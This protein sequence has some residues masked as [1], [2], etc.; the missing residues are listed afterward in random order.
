MLQIGKEAKVS[1]FAD[2]IY[3]R[4]R[5]IHKELIEIIN[6]CNK[7]THFKENTQKQ[8]AFLYAI[9]KAEKKDIKE[10]VSFKI[11]SP[12]IKYLEIS[13][14][15]DMGLLYHDTLNHVR[16]IEDL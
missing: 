9:N 13:L 7:V 8:I 11:I 2:N 1:L 16:K 10:S 5:K 4:L 14:A 15:K 3:R 6:Q 12:N